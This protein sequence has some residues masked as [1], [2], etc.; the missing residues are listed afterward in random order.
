[1]KAAMGVARRNRGANM[2]NRLALARSA[3]PAEDANLARALR[4]AKDEART[5]Q[6]ALDKVQSGLLLLDKDLRARYSNPALHVMFN[7]FSQDYI[8]EVQPSYEELLTDAQRNSA[9]D[10]D[11]YVNR[12]LEWVKS[13]D[14]KPMDLRMANGTILRCQL[15]TLPEGGRMLIYSDVTDIVHA[16]EELERLATIDGMTG[17]F[18]R[19]HF[20]NLADREWTRGRRYGYPI[21]FMMIDIDRF[22]S[23]N[24]SYGHQVGDEVIIHLAKLATANKREADLLA[25]VGGEEFALMLPETDLPGA[26]VAAERLRCEVSQ[27][28]PPHTPEGLA[29][30]ISVGVAASTDEMDDVSILMRAADDALYQAKRGGRD[31]VVC[32]VQSSEGACVPA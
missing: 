17:I 16:A 12:R 32:A 20:L 3:E 30:T 2:A 19:R 7:S 10:L 24:D 31:R 4:A 5:L 27:T 18:N 26:S 13:G 9:V 15:A 1:M 11:D 25:R 22:K 23:I 8:R 29:T 28:P 21:S 14:P 6:A